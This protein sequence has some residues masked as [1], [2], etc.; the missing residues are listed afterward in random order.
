MTSTW[1]PVPFR[2]RHLIERL[3]F[4]GNLTPCHYDEQENFFTQVTGCKRVIL[5]SPGQF[6]CLY[7]Y[8]VHHPHDRQSQVFLTAIQIHNR[9][10]T[11][12]VQLGKD[13]SFCFVDS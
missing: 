2:T 6:D 5:F 9:K 13:G 10:K 12:N 1:P 11:R 8:P 7:P 4:A 3:I